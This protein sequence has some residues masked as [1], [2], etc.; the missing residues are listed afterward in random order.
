MNTL[1]LA[2]VAATLVM[3]GVI[4]IVQIVHYPLMEKVGRGGYAAYQAAHVRR[5]SVVVMPAML[6]EVGTGVALVVWPPA[7]LPEWLVW[8]GMALLG[9]IW[10]ST[11]I[12]QV[13]AHNALHDGFD[14][15]AHRRLVSTNWIR[16]VA[17]GLRAA[18]V[19]AMLALLLSAR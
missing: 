9:V 1:L 2:H 5:I 16:T 14:A 18:L 6:I 3:F 11:W 19:L 4:L 15:A 7:G 12:W 17:W 13:P 8:A 10:L